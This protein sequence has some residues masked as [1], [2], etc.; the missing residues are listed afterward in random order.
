MRRT[1]SGLTAEHT[2]ILM[3][4]N[5]TNRRNFSHV[6]WSMFDA[7][8]AL[9]MFLATV[10]SSFGQPVITNQPA[11]QAAAPGTTVTF[12]VGATSSELLTYQW[13]KDPGNGFSDLADRTNAALVLANV[14]PWDA[15][16]YRVVVTNITGARTSAVARLY[17]VRTPLVT[18]NVVIDNFDDNKLTGWSPYGGKG[19]VN[20]T[21]TNQQ[22]KVWGYWPGVQTMDIG[23]TLA[24]GYLTRNWSV[25]NGQ[26][27]EW[28]V[29]LVGMNEHATMA[30]LDVRDGTSGA[31]YAL[32]KGKDFIH[33]C[34][35]TLCPDCRHGHFFHEKALIKSTNVVLALALTRVSPNVIIT[36][37]V[38]D[39]AND[40]A[41]LYE[42]SVVD[43]P[44][45][46]RTLTETEL[47]S[48][49]GMDLH[50]GTEL[51]PPLT[52]GTGVILIVFQYND[53]TRPPAE[54]TFDNLER[55]TSLF[56]V[57]RP[58]LAI[59]PLSTIPPKVN[60]TLSAAPNSSWAIERALELTGPWTQLSTLLIGTNGSAQFQDNSPA[61][62]YR[63]R[64]Q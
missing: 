25:L 49:S 44:K 41:V 64:L 55:R 51:G 58:E 46:D 11:P 10:S 20:L 60:L 36:T 14:Q 6:R 21:E 31:G 32:F 30:I 4:A 61:G 7:A 56:P 29:E 53:G 26:T 54:A 13:Q 63:T 16:D 3:K 34:K 23:D 27:V 5:H 35:P 50:T 24:D 17:I 52:S 38:L 12:Q 37:R 9:L 22:F 62:F 42:R 57:W 47:E 15:G 8:L 43:T 33:L 18:T 48:A 39:K 19:Q 40:N 59:Q 1:G 28:R 45:V 2:R